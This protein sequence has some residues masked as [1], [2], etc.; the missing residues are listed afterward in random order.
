VAG[1]RLAA[2]YTAIGAALD[3]GD[4]EGTAVVFAEK[5]PLPGGPGY[6]CDHIGL[7]AKLHLASS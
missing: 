4:A 1:S 3:A 6:V 7:R 2:R 5:E